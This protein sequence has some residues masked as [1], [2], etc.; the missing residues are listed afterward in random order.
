MATL[1]EFSK[2]I[3]FIGII[4]NPATIEIAP[5]WLGV[6]MQEPGVSTLVPAKLADLKAVVHHEAA[7][8]LS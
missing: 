2:T 3:Q 8:Q 6:T 4:H 1:V 7:I 5:N